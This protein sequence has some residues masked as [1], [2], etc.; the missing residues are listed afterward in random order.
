MPTLD[1]GVYAGVQQISSLICLATHLLQHPTSMSAFTKAPEALD[2]RGVL[3]TLLTQAVGLA[4]QKKKLS[5]AA[6][7]F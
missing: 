3:H 7:A 6:G 5:M 4:F 2:P 1:F